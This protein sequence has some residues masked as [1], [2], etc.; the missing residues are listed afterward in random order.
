MLIS[1]GL[2]EKMEKSMLMSV[3]PI[4]VTNNLQVISTEPKLNVEIVRLKS[5]GM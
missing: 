5:N 2:E 3:L 1:N 4:L